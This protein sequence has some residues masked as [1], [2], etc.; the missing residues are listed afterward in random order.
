M[1]LLQLIICAQIIGESIILYD[2]INFI[3]SCSNIWY[4]CFLSMVLSVTELFRLQQKKPYISHVILCVV[5]CFW[6]TYIKWTIAPYCNSMYQTQASSSL[7]Q[8]FEFV[9][10]YNNIIMLSSLGTFLAV[11]YE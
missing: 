10:W 2:N 11:K 7:W 4:C 8:L 9:F 6:T 1:L 5:A 3:S